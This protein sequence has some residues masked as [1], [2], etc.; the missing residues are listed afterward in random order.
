MPR[1]TREV[2]VGTQTLQNNIDKMFNTHHSHIDSLGMS[3]FQTPSNHVIEMSQMEYLGDVYGSPTFTTQ[4]YTIN[5]GISNSFP[6]LSN[7]ATNFE[8]Y[9]IK[10]MQFEFRSH[11]FDMISSSN[12]Q[13]GVVCMGVQYDALDSPFMSKGQMENYEYTQSVPSSDN[14]IHVLD[15][16][17]KARSDNVLK[18]LYVRTGSAAANTDLRLYDYG[19]FNIGVEG[20]QSTGLIGELWVKYKVCFYRQTVTKA[21][22][23]NIPY[24][25]IQGSADFD[26]TNYFGLTPIVSSGSF[27]RPLVLSDRIVLPTNAPLGN[28]LATF[29]WQ[30]QNGAIATPT[31]TLSS[32]FANLNLFRGNAT[33]RVN[34]GSYSSTVLT[35]SIAFTIVTPPVP[36]APTQQSAIMLSGGTLPVAPGLFC[37]VVITAITNGSQT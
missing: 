12:P 5:P 22:G 30:G 35:I 8:M 21:L 11:V 28:Y 7:I 34:P 19:I 14:C 26:T 17:K 37:D 15:V 6:H 2:K 29:Y 10:E 27:L 1:N 3:K 32:N 4:R 13:I 36:N 23:Y 31:L 20:Q 33:A 25:H 24:C 18:M 9:V 16:S